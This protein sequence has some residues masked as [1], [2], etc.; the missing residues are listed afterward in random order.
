MY[1]Q[2]IKSELKK[3]FKMKMNIIL[4][5]VAVLGTLF[6]VGLKYYEFMDVYGNNTQAQTQQGEIL[7]N[8]H[9]L[10]YISETRHQYAGEWTEEK[11]NQIYQDY[12]NFVEKYSTDVIDDDK[13][14]S[15]YLFN[16]KKILEPML[17][18]EL[19]Y[20]QYHEYLIENG[21]NDED[22]EPE[23]ANE[24]IDLEVY[25]KSTPILEAANFA[26]GSANGYGGIDTTSIK[27]MLE[28]LSQLLIEKKVD[29][30]KDYLIKYDNIPDDMSD[31]DIAIV[32]QYIKDQVT[33]V[34]TYYDSTVSNEILIHALDNCLWIPL[35]CL[36]IILANTFGIERQYNVEQ[37]VYPTQAGLFKTTI[38]KILV[39]T[40]LSMGTMFITILLCYLLGN[41]LVP[42][43]T[44]D[45]ATFSFRTIIPTIETQT[46][47]NYKDIIIYTISLG[48]IASLAVSTLTLGLS[49]LLKNKFATIII[50][51]I[52]FAVGLGLF[53]DIPK[54][55]YFI[56]PYRMTQIN[57]YAL[58]YNFPFTIFNGELIPYTIISI[59]FWLVVTAITY[60]FIIIRSRM[61]T[62]RQI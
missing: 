12:N 23:L 34:P 32:V 44:W 56:H 2:L 45:I 57:A 47:L 30:D 14:Q 41:Y 1:I 24:I 31:E 29:V 50:L 26:Y 49:Y 6:C 22:Y 36:M 53:V 38:A 28:E 59:L 7:T 40:L 25:T 42:I 46:M 54:V 33:S 18:N 8:I 19:T 9:Y 15:R 20:K 17:K 21:D 16:Y 13:M 55:L 11:A 60:S 5:I 10:N 35:I 27:P 3:I 62:A 58:I 37:I 48:M 4:L 43:Y 51:F 39:G 52:F 61:R